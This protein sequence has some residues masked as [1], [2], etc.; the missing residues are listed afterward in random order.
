MLINNKQ[1]K[2]EK[3]SVIEPDIDQLNIINSNLNQNDN[4]SNNPI[5]KL[6]IQTFIHMEKANEEYKNGMIC[7]KKVQK[8]IN[9]YTNKST[10]NKKNS[11][12]SKKATGFGES[13]IVPEEL[14]NLLEINEN[15]LPR[16]KLTKKVYEYIENNKLKS[17]NNKRILR[18][19]DKLASA[20]KLTKEQ[21]QKINTSQDQKD[22]DGLNFYNIQT[23]IAKLYD[24]FKSNNQSV[25]HT[26][27]SLQNSVQN[28]VKNLLQDQVEN[29]T[30]K[31]IKSSISDD[32]D[33]P[34]ELLDEK[35]QNE[36]KIKLEDDL[37]IVKKNKKNN[38]TK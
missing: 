24:N 37:V 35:E 11:T 17:P 32:L 31:S 13:T 20:L 3:S 8:I 18:V 5:N 27:H 36:L 9:K 19:D 23:W 25:K 2:D 28:Q 22:K 1:I 10:K 30:I 33:L 6:I 4:E 7:L 16:T 12:F 21:I 26:S 14:K 15:M 29:H 38:K 34:K